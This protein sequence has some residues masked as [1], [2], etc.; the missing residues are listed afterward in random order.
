MTKI[1]IRGLPIDVG[2]REQIL[3]EAERLRQTGGAILTVNPLMLDSARDRAVLS[4]FSRF[5]LK[6]PDGRGLLRPIRKAGGKGEIFPGIELAEALLSD[7]GRVAFIGGRGNVAERAFLNM[8]ARYPIEK[9]FV[10]DGYS[11]TDRAV[12]E[13]LVTTR[14]DLCFVCLGSPKQ[15]F[16]IDRL[17]RF[18]TGTVYLG[19]GGTFDVWSG[20]TPRAPQI[21]RKTGT[22]WLYR[23]AREPRRLKNLPA[24]F[25][26]R[27]EREK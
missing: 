17:R 18:S 14:P 11:F 5:E 10:F 12:A 15:E 16:L 26:F 6:I 9:A 21:F 27:L 19:L 8:K 1:E 20:D 13:A 3:A 24:L 22:E 25:R 4:L 2:T 23:M 7:G